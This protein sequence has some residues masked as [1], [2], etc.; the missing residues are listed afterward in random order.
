MFRALKVE[1]ASKVHL[2]SI[3]VTAPDTT[4]L[5]QHLL[6]HSDIRPPSDE[7]GN[8]P[9][10]VPK[11]G[12]TFSSFSSLFSA[13]DKSHCASVFRLGHALFDPID[14]HL[15]EEVSDDI[16]ERVYHL[17][18]ADALSSWLTRTVSSYVE[19]DIRN[20]GSKDSA[21]LAFYYLTGN[22]VDKAVETLVEANHV[23]LA[24]LIAQVPGAPE[25]R[26]DV[27]EQLRIW[28]EEKVDRYI[29]KPLLKLY[30][31]AA[32]ECDIWEGSSRREIVDIAKGLDWLRVLGLQLWYS[33]NLGDTLQN[34]FEVYEQLV[35][36][37]DGKLAAPT[38]FYSESQPKFS[39][40]IVTD[41]LF[42]LMKLGFSISTTLE[43]ALNP[44]S[45]SPNPR[46][47]RMPWL[48][49]ILLSRCLR[50]YDFTDRYL[51]EAMEDDTG[52]TQV[53]EGYSQMSNLL[54]ANFAAQLQQDGLIQ[55][56]A[57]V[58]LFLEDD[59]L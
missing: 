16:Q 48:L 17:R 5:L 22:Q 39:E 44:L 30:A 10:T 41:G 47:Y 24:T 23:K 55:E 26:E 25:F 52:S 4:D 20:T 29:S 2:T 11:A 37:S 1:D 50:A 38:P 51:Y 58:L 53:V 54:T 27:R 9:F 13:Q 34:T 28:K 45:F 19:E 49:Y 6:S 43:D 32:G 12:V 42:N 15:K 31:L 8:T 56:A 3:R 46:D 40:S 7:N 14:L 18:R 57:Y 33:A 21:D 35:K 59:D 36:E